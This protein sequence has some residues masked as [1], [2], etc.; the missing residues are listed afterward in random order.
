MITTANPYPTSILSKHAFDLHYSLCELALSAGV[1]LHN[2]PFWS[3]AWEQGVKV[4][5]VDAL[6]YSTEAGTMYNYKQ[7]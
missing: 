5:I 3:W 6:H 1:D 7:A 2:S 4:N